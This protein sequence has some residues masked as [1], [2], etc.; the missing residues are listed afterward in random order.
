MGTVVIPSTHSGPPGIGHG[1]YV[2]GLLTP[3]V[4]GAAQVTLRRPAPL[5][6]DLELSASETG[7]AISD[8]SGVIADVTAST[9]ELDIPP[10]PSLDEAR[11]AEAGSPSRWYEKGVHPTCF[12]CA[13]FRDDQIGLAIGV[14]PVDG[15]D[16]RKLFAGTALA[17]A[18]GR[19]LA[20]SKQTWFGR[21]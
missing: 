15:R 5:N 18:D 14:G 20:A 19:A 4:S 3:H 9:L 12:G 1:G 16:G 8:A 6:V 11:T 10:I 2:A 21:G 7:W 17:T 13:L